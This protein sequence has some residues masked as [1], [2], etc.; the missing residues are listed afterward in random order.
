MIL[1]HPST[2]V[3]LD[4]FME[5][6]PHGLLVSGPRGT[7]L[8][9]IARELVGHNELLLVH[10]QKLGVIDDAIGTISVEQVRNLYEQ[11]RSKRTNE[12]VV[13]V[14][15]A[16]RM[17]HAA[18][19][20]FLKLLEEP[21]QAVRFIITSHSADEL[22]PTIQS[23]VQRIDVK[24]VQTTQSTELLDSLGVSDATKRTQLLFMADGLPAELTRL[25][26]DDEYFSRRAGAVR[27]AREFLGASIY[28]KLLLISKLGDT[29]PEVQV[30]IDD[31]IKQLRLALA[32]DPSQKILQQIDQL[33]Q[34]SERI[35]RSGNIKLALTRAVL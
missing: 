23:R 14:A 4:R 22:L 35:A 18:Q 9:T 21:P 24:P 27:M 31:C 19:N 6:T 12:L 17:T 16:E 10:P 32:K 13:I 25:A 34:A 28:Q 3:V 20:A 30:F 7:G 26:S 1:V 11:T 8:R 29:R 2:R 15:N 5:N 33:L